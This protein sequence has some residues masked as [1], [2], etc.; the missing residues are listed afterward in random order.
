[1]RARPLA[2]AT[3]A[4]APAGLS[5]SQTLRRYMCGSFAL[6]FTFPRFQLKQYLP[7]PVSAMNW[8]VN[9]RAPFS[10]SALQFESS[11]STTWRGVGVVVLVATSCGLPV[12]LRP[13][14]GAG[15]GAELAGARVVEAV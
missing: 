11:M 3:W 15:D 1:M 7:P 8:A 14:L 5:H 4:S 2:F 10:V 6:A 12:Y 13:P 9:V